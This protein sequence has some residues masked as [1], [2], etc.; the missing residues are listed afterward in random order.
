MQLQDKIAVVTGGASGIGAELS[1][2]FAT[3][4]A[5]LSGLA[6]ESFLLIPHREVLTYTQKRHR[7]TIVG[8]PEY[9][10]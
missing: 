4:S 3:K 1:H 10:G 5:E 9:G 8:W 6:G 2:R 7:T